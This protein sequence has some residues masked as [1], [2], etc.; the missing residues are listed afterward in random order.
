MP[1][2]MENPKGIRV[3]VPDDDHVIYRA[4]GRVEKICEHGVGHPIGH[5]R[6]WELW[7][8]IHGCC[9]NL[10]CCKDE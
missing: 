3:P 5:L 2:T 6:K 9:G 4:D 7:M 1:D 10:E 8:G